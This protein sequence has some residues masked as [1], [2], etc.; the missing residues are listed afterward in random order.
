MLT[1]IRDRSTGWFAWGLALLIIIPMAFWGIQD[2][3]SG[4]VDP[5][6]VSVG[7]SNITQREFQAALQNQQQR[8]RQQFG[9]NINDSFL[10]SPDFKQNVLQGIMQQRAIQHIAE[11]GVYSVGD[12]QLV[13]LIKQNPVFQEEGQFSQDAFNR[14]AAQSGFARQQFEENIREQAVLQQV[15]SGY[16]ESSFVLPEETR[17]V[18]E[19]Q[20]EERDFELLTIDSAQFREKVEISDEDLQQYYA[21]NVSSLLKEASTS[22]QYVELDAEAFKQDL[23][24][25]EDN[26]LALYE[27][28][29]EA[30]RSNEVR[31]TRHIL[32]SL[33]EGEDK[34]LEKA[35]E[36]KERLGKGEDFA[37]LAKEFS[38]DPGSANNGG[39]LGKVQKGQMVAEFE[40]VN[41]SIEQGVVSDPVKS[42]FGYHL[43]KVD[44][45]QLPAQKTFE[46]VR[47]DLE[48]Q[49]LDRL[50]QDI[51]IEKEERLRNL[52]YEFPES[53]ETVAEEL[54]LELKTTETFTQANGAGIA[55]NPSVRQVAFSE[56]VS[57][58]RLNSEPSEHK[59]TVSDQA[60][61]LE[62]A[63][64]RE[65]FSMTLDDPIR[66]LEGNG[67]KSYLIK[68]NTVVAGDVAD[69]S[70]SI[71]QQTQALLTQRSGNTFF[72]DY[73]DNYIESI[74]S[75][76]NADL[77]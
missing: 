26:L 18:L 25:N 15:T 22:I 9:Q 67:G 37:T 62:Q 11:R 23:E 1:E 64:L 65:A 14:Y 16:R 6:V 8:F 61:G 36:L 20:V 50:A 71:K 30:L 55:A 59:T 33:D 13:E 38:Q 46:E 45:I 41:F 66:S 40:E 32:I 63:V 42:Q 34:A 27:E 47:S 56:E 53:L 10:N 48:Q 74:A 57:V 21:D 51:L 3:A 75:E 17:E 19:W 73:L 69:A 29:K 4:D 70:D 44:D 58:D 72:S 5:A 54:S 43:I 12:S 76:I 2:Y 28:N 35:N 49:E 68:L 77:L 60:S 52:A 39:S 24:V 7:D 31:E